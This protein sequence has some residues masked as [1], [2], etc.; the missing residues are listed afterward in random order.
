MKLIFPWSKL[1]QDDV[2]Y[3]SYDVHRN[4]LGDILSPIIANYFG[5]KKIKR[6][7]KRSSK[8]NE[9][10]FM[11]G[12][13]IERCNKNSIIWGSGLMYANSILKEFP[14][15]ILAVRGPLTRSRL[16]E[17]GIPCPEVYGDPALLLPEVYPNTNPLVKYK[18]GII[19]HFRDKENSWLKAHFYKNMDIKIIDIQNKNPLK[20]V[21]EIL[22]CEKIISSS[23]HGIIIS[24]AY[25]IPSVWFEF[26]NLVEGSGFKF[27]DYFKSVGRLDEKPY[28]LTDF[29]NLDQILDVFQEYEIEIDL[30]KLKKTFPF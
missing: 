3:L 22:E 27:R 29:K 1:K 10:Y 5:S 15:K 16:I 6:I 19:P 18:L 2:E 24:D 13:I 11:I 9:H 30:E 26:S 21:D 14:K 8:N 4:N 25:K 12:S 20:V 7:S 23:L 28:Q 17:L